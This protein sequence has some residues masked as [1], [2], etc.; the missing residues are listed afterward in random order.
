MVGLRKH[1]KWRRPER[2]LC[3]GDV[4]VLKEE[5]LVTSRWPLARVTETVEGG[6]GLV[7]VVKLK[8]KDGTYTRPVAKVALLPCENYFNLL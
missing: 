5:N 7:R 4:V 6:D 3:V 2:N 1:S 8:T